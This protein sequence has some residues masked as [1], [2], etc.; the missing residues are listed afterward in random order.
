MFQLLCNEVPFLPTRDRYLDKC[1][2]YVGLSFVANASPSQPQVAEL[3]LLSC[4][5]VESRSYVIFLRTT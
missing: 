3:H 2:N 4:S 1:L 5:E